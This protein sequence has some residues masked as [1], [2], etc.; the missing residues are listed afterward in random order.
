MW[1]Q[2]F[3]SVAAVASGFSKYPCITFGPFAI[4]SPMPLASG[5]SMRTSMPGSG[6][7]TEPITGTSPGRITVS[8]GELSVIP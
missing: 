2:P 3:W 6:R 5:W 8:T 7:P 1:S 4:T